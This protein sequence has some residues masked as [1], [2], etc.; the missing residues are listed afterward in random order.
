MASTCTSAVPAGQ[1]LPRSEI[2]LILTFDGLSLAMTA[3][4]VAGARLRAMVRIVAKYILDGFAK[5]WNE[6][7]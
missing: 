2:P 6:E 5:V 4:R 7:F 3:P 1:P